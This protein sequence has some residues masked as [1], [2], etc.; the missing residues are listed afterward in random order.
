MEYQIA[1]KFYVGE[2][3]RKYLPKSNNYTSADPYSG[4]KSIE[5]NLIVARVWAT[6]YKFKGSLHLK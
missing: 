5:L 3:L 1:L 6:T 2:S 4:I